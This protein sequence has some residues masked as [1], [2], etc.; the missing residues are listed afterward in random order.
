M[1]QETRDGLAGAAT[2]VAGIVIAIM[3]FQGP[4]AAPAGQY[5]IEAAFSQVDGLFVGDEVRMG[6]IKIGEVVSNSLDDTFTA[7]LGLSIDVAVKL[8]AD[9]SAAIHTDGLFGTKFIE[10][11]PGGD[12]E[13]IPPGGEISVTQGSVVVEDLLELIIA[14]AKANAKKRKN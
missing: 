10:L 11:V 7:R 12:E 6:G 14:Q 8:P 1:N 13:S 5:R 3:T 9:T 4:A 2:V